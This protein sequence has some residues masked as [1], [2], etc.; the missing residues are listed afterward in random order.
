MPLKSHNGLARFL[1]STGFL[2]RG[3]SYLVPH[4][5]AKKYLRNGYGAALSFGIK[6]EA[7]AT[8]INNLKLI[9]HVSNLG[10]AKTVHIA[11]G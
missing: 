2:T 4:H 6:V 3:W 5:L 8:F 7:A 1:L 9:S 11:G 10:D